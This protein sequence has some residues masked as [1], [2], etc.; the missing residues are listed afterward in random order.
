MNQFCFIYYTL[1]NLISFSMF[2]IDKRK[3]IKNRY[4]ISEIAL[5]MSELLGG[6]FGGYLSMNLFHHKTKKVK[7]HFV[8]IFSII[9]HIYIILCILI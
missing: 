7:F 6:C 3:A 8:S 2:F 1:I 9:L 4:R 5:L